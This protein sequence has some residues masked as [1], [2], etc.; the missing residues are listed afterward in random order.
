MN[1][2]TLELTIKAVDEASKELD[3]VQKSLKDLGGGVDGANKNLKDFG[4]TQVKAG[5]GSESMAGAVFKG[6]L[7]LEAVKKGLEIAIDFT[8]QSVEAYIEAEKTM[9]RVRA[10]VASMGKSY[11]EVGP[12]IEA[13]GDKM[14]R[15]G[16]DDEAAMESMTKL[17]KVAGGDLKQGM[18]LAKMAADLTASGFGTLES[19]TDNLEK[20]MTGKGSRALMEYRINLSDTATTAE[21]LDAIHKKIT[22]TTE[23]YANTVP[24]KIDIVKTAYGNL[25]ETVGQGF[26]E[27]FASAIDTGTNFDDALDGI[28]TTATYLKYTIFEVVQGVSLMISGFKNG[29]N[30]MQIMG[31]SVLAVT[32]K[33]WGGTKGAESLAKNLEDGDK[34]AQNI[35]ETF[36]KMFNPTQA[37]EEAHKKLATATKGSGDAAKGM[38]FDVKNA[39]DAA[40]ASHKQHD[41]AVVKL[42]D[43]YKKLKSDTATSLAEMTGRFISDMSSMSAAID[44]TKRAIQ[45][46][47]TAYSRG[48][49][50]DTASVAEK[51]VESE[52]KVKNLKEQL[53]AETDLKKKTDLQKQLDAEQKN[54]DSS[55][56][57]QKG[58]QTAIT[59]AK[60]R[61][62]LTALQRDIEDYNTRRTLATQE[63]IQKSADLQKDLEAQSAKQVAE[64]NLFQDKTAKIRSLDQQAT[65][66]YVANSK[67][68]AKQTADE[69]N[70]SISLYNQLT[71]SINAAKS[72]SFS[73][74]L[75]L[76]S[77]PVSGKR[78]LGGNVSGDST[79]LVGENGPELFTPSSAGSIIPNN[80]TGSGG[81]QNIVINVTGTFLSETAAREVGNMIIKNFKTMSRVGA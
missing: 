80:K 67:I 28:N 71:A 54:L 32:E 33:L 11:E 72:A 31:D 65:D 2:N 12:Q 76:V 23:D 79:Y 44:K 73:S 5:Q 6:G 14:A 17:A 60:R 56:E 62:G 69:V 13:F 8:K 20:V 70:A 41:D 78:A 26:V 34:N 22:Q 24:G 50:D 63:F 61:A 77:S 30:T 7:A 29:I 43:T 47:Q 4:D 58:N 52:T 42:N 16:V 66:E 37:M 51:I 49:I 40:A 39:N 18:D 15:L 75:G 25:Q 74:S 21:Q 1:N 38:S 68:R 9:S 45:D 35:T 57:F 59:E 55:A 10:S 3:K 46:L 64:W 27:A 36:Q 81:G 53:A 48:A 19:N